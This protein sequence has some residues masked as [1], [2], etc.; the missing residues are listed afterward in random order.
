[1]NE[2]RAFAPSKIKRRYDYCPDLP[3][4]RD[5]YFQYPKGA[6][7]PSVVDLRHELSRVEDQADLGSCTANAWV[8]AVEHIDKARDGHYHNWS[9]LFLYYNERALHGDEAWDTGANIR[10][11]AKALAKRGI[12]QE[13]HWKYDIA[14]FAEMPPASCFTEGLTHQAVVYSRVDQTEDAMLSALAQ[15]N[16]IVVGF[17]VYESF[18]STDTAKTGIVPI[19][20]PK[21]K[22]LGG[23][24]VL[25]VGYNRDKQAFIVRNS[26]GSHWGDHGYCYFPFA[27]LL[28]GDLAEDFWIIQSLENLTVAQHIGQ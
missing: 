15:R 5:Y 16:P 25:V 17:T 22:V 12:C 28:D 19:P 11:G 13:T 18:E 26:W 6:A 24:A 4:K 9:R 8:G 10:D 7:L 23:H 14:K 20:G 1:M 27:Y 21:E 3:D 2:F